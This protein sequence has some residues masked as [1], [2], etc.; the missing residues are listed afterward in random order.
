MHIK[1]KLCDYF[2]YSRLGGHGPR[3]LIAD[4]SPNAQQEQTS[5]KPNIYIVKQ[6]LLLIYNVT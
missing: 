1:Q 6:K 4:R 5:N 2:V 3:V